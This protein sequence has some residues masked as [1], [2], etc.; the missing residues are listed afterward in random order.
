MPTTRYSRQ[1][2][3]ATDAT[4][5][6]VLRAWLPVALSSSAEPTANR[7]PRFRL[8]RRL[9]D[10]PSDTAQA[11][12]R[13]AQIDQPLAARGLDG[14]AAIGDDHHVGGEGGRAERCQQCR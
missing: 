9:M 10:A 2:G 4:M 1:S 5:A 3:D 6:A 11:A 7:R 13:F 14:V 8:N 12:R